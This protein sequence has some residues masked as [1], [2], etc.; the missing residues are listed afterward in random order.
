MPALAPM[1]PAFEGDAF[2]PADDQAFQ[3]GFRAQLSA[4]SDLAF[5]QGAFQEEPMVGGAG[6]IASA[7]TFGAAHFGSSITPGAS[8]SASDSTSATTIGLVLSGAVAVGD[9]IVV[10]ASRDTA[11]GGYG[12]ESISDTLGN[13]WTLIGHDN[14]T[15]NVQGLFWWYTIVTHAG[16]PTI[17]VTFPFSSAFR[18][19]VAQA[20]SGIDS[21]GLDTATILSG[22]STTGSSTDNAVTGSITPS[23]NGCLLIGVIN[24]T[25]NVAAVAAGT[26]FSENL[27][28]G[29]SVTELELESF[30]QPTASTAHASW[31]VGA[32][33]AGAVYTAAFASFKPNQGAVP[34]NTSPPVVSGTPLEVGTSLATTDG[35]WTNSPTGFLYQWQ[36]DSGA[37]GGGTPGLPDRSLSAWNGLLPSGLSVVTVTN[38]SQWNAARAAI[39]PGQLIDVVNPITIP[40]LDIRTKFAS[41]V[42]IRFS[43]V[44]TIQNTCHLEA[45]NLLIYGGVVDGPTF[46]SGS[47]SGSGVEMTNCTNVRWWGGTIKN[48]AAHGYFAHANGGP[49]HLLDVSFDISKCGLDLSRDPHAEKGTGL[50]P[51]YIGSGDISNAGTDG[52]F[53]IVGHDC[54]T[55]SNQLGNNIH[56]SEFWIDARRYNKVA[57][58]QVAGNAMQWWSKAGIPNLVNIHVHFCYGEDLQGRM[59]DVNGLPTGEATNVVVEFARHGGTIRLSPLYSAFTGITYLDCT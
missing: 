45:S 18:A 20:W 1:E 14:D 28:T 4:L 49:N 11:S 53:V 37:G 29:T 50:H 58:S 7:E 52:Q 51:C 10:A 17:T 54:D 22:T 46:V 38:L 15:A 34:V 42:A 5:Q 57:I 21:S 24:I 35:G 23:L 36:R 47:Y 3:T 41:T 30:I 44:V 27:D 55:G 19:M 59:S 56:D 39:A 6:A 43:A 12:S 13:T 48:C 33:T 8:G 2:Q 31:T 9:L 26:G 40:T 16:T 25:H 32:P